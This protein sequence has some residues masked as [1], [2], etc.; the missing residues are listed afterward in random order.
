M[1]PNQLLRKFGHVQIEFKSL[2]NVLTPSR[3][4]L[5]WCTR[6]RD[7]RFFCIEETRQHVNEMKQYNFF[8]ELC[9]FLLAFLML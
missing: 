3:V 9:D 6:L 8:I 7:E 1:T 2:L 4:R 5:L